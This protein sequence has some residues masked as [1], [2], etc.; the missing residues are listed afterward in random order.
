MFYYGNIIY[1][2]NLPLE[3]ETIYAQVVWT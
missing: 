3:C 1:G 2:Y